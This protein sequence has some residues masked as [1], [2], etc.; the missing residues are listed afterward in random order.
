[1]A[2]NLKRFKKDKVSIVALVVLLLLYLAILF[3]SFISPYEKN[4]SNRKLSYAPPST[5][6]TITKDGKFSR[7]YTYNLI[8]EF[9]PSS[10]SMNFKEDRSQKHY[11]KFLQM[12]LNIN[13]LASLRQKST[14]LEQIKMAKYIF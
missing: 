10:L 12:V 11:I 8:R 5:I 9:D 14:F 6:Y 7:P 4:Y 13:Y 3:A 2:S 1:M